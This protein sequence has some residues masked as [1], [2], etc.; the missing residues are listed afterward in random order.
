MPWFRHITAN[1][2]EIDLTVIY[3]ARPTPT[4]QGTGFGRAFEW[5]TNLIDGYRWRVV[6]ESRAGDEFAAGR[7]RGLD[8]T[9]NRRRR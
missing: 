9:G 5:D 6:R 4:Q 2:P 8:V 7:F 3:A 1:C